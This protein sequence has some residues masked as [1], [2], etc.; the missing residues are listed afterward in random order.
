MKKVFSDKIARIIKNRERLEKILE[1]KIT[2]NSGEIF[3]NGSPEKEY[4][5]EKVIDALS[6][7]FPFSAAML[8]K[9]E[10]YLLETIN[11]KEYTKRKDLERIRAR[12]IGKKGKTLRAIS[13]ITNCFLELKDNS[14]WI[15]G[16]F[17]NVKS[18]RD[19]IISLIRGAKQSSIYSFLEKNRSKHIID[20]GLKE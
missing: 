17:E 14:V 10:E 3:V 11:I 13:H 7:G 2:I 20:F 18:A 8:I 5:A 19:G 15:I 12:I 16:S 4:V 6:A 1:V 9:D